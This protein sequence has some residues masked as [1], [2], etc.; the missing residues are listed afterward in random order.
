MTTTYN[1]PDYHS[2]FFEYKNLDKIHGKST[3]DTIAKKLN[4]LKRN[5]QRFTTIL[6]GGQLG[7]LTLI[8][9]PLAYNV[10]P[11][12]AD[13]QHPV[14]P[15]TFSPVAVATGATTCA[16]SLAQLTAADI[17]TQKIAHSE[18]RR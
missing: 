17:P 11:N 8:I 10:I 14:D 16:T 9:S 4:Q 13:C 12:L 2:R 18:T 1:L 3:I 5:V 7:F 15:G 6:G